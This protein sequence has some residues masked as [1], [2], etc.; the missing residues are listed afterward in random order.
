MSGISYWEITE[1]ILNL[2]E[3]RTQN[4]NPGQ[5]YIYILGL[6]RIHQH[7]QSVLI[8]PPWVFVYTS[9]NRCK[10]AHRIRTECWM[11]ISGIM[12]GFTLSLPHYLVSLWSMTYICKMCQM[13]RVTVWLQE[14]KM[15]PY[16]A[17]RFI[18]E[19]SIQPY[20]QAT[21]IHQLRLCMWVL[22]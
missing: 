20:P 4:L 15:F 9:N 7:P 18:Q 16:E 3:G 6:G 12:I 5:M 10:K 19:S 17:I 14:K 21:N 11:G 1:E 22:W 8:T 2:L 13:H